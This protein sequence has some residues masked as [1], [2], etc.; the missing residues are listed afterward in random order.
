MKTLLGAL[1][2]AAV[3]M[4]TVSIVFATTTPQKQV[5]PT[6]PAKWGERMVNLNDDG[7]S[8]DI[9]KYDGYSTLLSLDILS[10][11][12]AKYSS[13]INLVWHGA[14][15]AAGDMINGI[16]LEVDSDGHCTIDSADK[17]VFAHY[18]FNLYELIV[19]T[20]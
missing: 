14:W 16:I 17:D 20:V 8:W 9:A 12:A 4:S 11:D 18:R 2:A 15:I 10:W 19:M 5:E 3:V 1:T 6:H 7:H 13:Q